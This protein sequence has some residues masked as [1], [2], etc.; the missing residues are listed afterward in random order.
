MKS[1]Y[2]LKVIA[3]TLSLLKC[4]IA[5]MLLVKTENLKENYRGGSQIGRYQG[6]YNR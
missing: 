6:N 3:T 5:L 2:R 1:V 4:G